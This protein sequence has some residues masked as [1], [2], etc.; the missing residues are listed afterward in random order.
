MTLTRR[1]ALALPALAL[2]PTAALAAPAP[3]FSLKDADGV[4]RT[5]AEFRG[6][7][8]VMEWINEGCPYVKKHYQGNM[9]ATQKAALADGAVWLSVCSSAPGQQ[10]HVDGAGAKRFIA[11]KGA[12]PTAFLLDPTGVAGKAWGAKTTPHMYIVDKAGELVYQGG[13][14]DKPTANVAD[15]AG[16]TNYVKAA[17]ADLKAGRPVKVAFSKPYGCA[18]KY[19]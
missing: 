2:F 4:T 3:A 16:A 17:L 7:V 11:D 12:S 6:K 14:D 8:V 1:S 13:I 9:Q 19:A 5:L 10:G 15:I 18:V